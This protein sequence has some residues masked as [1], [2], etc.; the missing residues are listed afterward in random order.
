M[1]DDSAAGCPEIHEDGDELP[2]SDGSLAARQPSHLCVLGDA[3]NRE[4]KF[5][6][7]HNSRDSAASTTDSV[8]TGGRAHPGTRRNRAS[9]ITSLMAGL[10]L[11]GGRTFSSTE[12][13]CQIGTAQSQ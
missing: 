2:P 10:P 12:S 13:G 3:V 5:S 1:V 11:T 4:D 9:S 6:C 8:R 7:K